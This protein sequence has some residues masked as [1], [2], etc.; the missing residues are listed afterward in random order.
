MSSSDPMQ[1]DQNEILSD[2]TV[3]IVGGGPVGLLLATVLAF[4][5][6]KSLLLERNKTTTKWPKMDLTNAR[7][8][9]IFRKLGL[10]KG[11]RSRGMCNFHSKPNKNSNTTF[12]GVASHI[13]YTVLF[14]SGLS[15]DKPITQWLHPS[16]DEYRKN[17][18]KQNDGT[19]PL[20]PY[21]RI[22]QSI[23]EAWLKESCDSN[24]LIDVRYGWKVELVEGY[25]G[26]VKTTAVDVD[27]GK[28]ASFVS[29]Y[30]VGCDGGS[31]K[32]RAG[33]GI[34]LDGGPTPGYVLLVHFKSTDL[35]R[36][37]KQGQFWHIFFIRNGQ[38]GGAMI[39]QDEIDTW[40]VHLFLPLEADHL[41]MSSE[42]AVY[43]VLGGMGGEYEIKID[44][45]LVRSTYRPIIAVARSYSALNG[46][47]FLA[48]DSA[49]QNIP[50]GGYGMNM[51]IADA[52]DLGW[53]LAAVINGYGKKGL[54]DSYELE[55]RPV[56]FMSVEH[57]KVHMGT[58]GAISEILQPDPSMVD[59]NCDEGRRLREEIHKHYQSH[60]GENKD[61]GVEMGFHYKSPIN[62]P[63]EEG[64]PEPVWEPSCYSP[65]TLP[66]VR[67]PHV[68]LNDG[69]PIFDLYGKDYA[70]VE[71]HDQ[72]DRGSSFL[73]E[74]AK[75]IS[76]PLKHLILIGEDNARKIWQRP[77]VLIRPDGHVSWRG[78]TI[79]D[80]D[81]AKHIV[82]AMVGSNMMVSGLKVAFGCSGS[83]LLF[84]QKDE[85]VIE[86]MG[87]FQ[88]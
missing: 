57:S 88:T 64:R 87:D 79:K 24:P 86:K 84:T 72:I 48:G 30:A 55:R 83:D 29:K 58:H 18:I 67:A 21:Q 81:A 75:E 32:V 1:R 27:S 25:G 14:S 74:A 45:V 31:S 22:S 51:G 11:L 4:H 38:M 50:T 6:V 26:D 61:L 17:I 56:A 2:D 68:F 40:T 34:P 23:F 16:V 47:V 19:H 44:Q 43:T 77:L 71:F 73:V 46:R 33:L 37:Q 3:L 39:A 80:L 8:M 85:F 82:A 76:V 49:H 62:I 9:E 12:I 41:S 36:L 59:A 10:A 53:K 65:T 20:E 54:L 66:G 70:L 69:T 15:R 78:D 7:S 52:Y 42:D 28:R 13:P 35:S 63:D 60:D 5:G